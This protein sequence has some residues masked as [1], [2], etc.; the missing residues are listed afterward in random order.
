MRESVV[1]V[2]RYFLSCYNC[3]YGVEFETP[4]QQMATATSQNTSQKKNKFTASN[5][6]KLIPHEAALYNLYNEIP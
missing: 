6:K 5:V 2:E 1:K 3:F 4:E